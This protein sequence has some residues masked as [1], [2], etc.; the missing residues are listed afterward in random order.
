MHSKIGKF[1]LRRYLISVGP[2]GLEGS[3]SAQL[4]SILGSA[5][6]AA[7]QT[8]SD[9]LNLTDQ[10]QLPGLISSTLLNK[11]NL[12]T[13]R[14]VQLDWTRSTYL[15]KFNLTEHSSS[16]TVQLH[17]LV[18]WRTEIQLI[19]WLIA[20]LRAWLLAWLLDCVIACLIACMIDWLIDWL[21]AW[22]IACL[23][24]W[25]LGC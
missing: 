17:G 12:T 23:I 22:L 5:R 1:Q 24:D 10:V 8:W 18:R 13:I 19:D 7:V 4:S 2:A 25:L 11:F 16:R 15:D 21:I 3:G 6:A 9:Q 14:T 20:W